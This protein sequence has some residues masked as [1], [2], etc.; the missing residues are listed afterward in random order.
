MV[1]CGAAVSSARGICRAK[2]SVRPRE[3]AILRSRCTTAHGRLA[4]RKH[5]QCLYSNRIA[6]VCACLF[7]LTHTTLLFI[8]SYSFARGCFLNAFSTLVPS[9]Y[10]VIFRHTYHTSVIVASCPCLMV[11]YSLTCLQTSSEG[12]LPPLCFAASLRSELLQP[13]SSTACSVAG[14]LRE[15]SLRYYRQLQGCSIVMLMPCG[16]RCSH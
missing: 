12:H 5:F 9:F 16:S 3:C 6:S 1:S 4:P 11:E 10:P 13:M 8:T 7:V 2:W 15:G 14:A